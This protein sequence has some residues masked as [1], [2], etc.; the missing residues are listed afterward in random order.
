MFKIKNAHLIT[1]IILLLPIALWYGIS[2]NSTLPMFFD[3]KV[4]SIDLHQIF[5]AIMGLYLGNIML[6]TIGVL[7]PNY[8]KTATVANIIF[9]GGLVLGRLI[10]LFADGLPAPLF[11]FGLVGELVLGTWGLINL[12]KY[13]AL[14]L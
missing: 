1:S 6:W 2:P 4:E 14:S 10:S 8:W 9:M 7:Y 13:E 5:R 12:K 11:Q 3:F